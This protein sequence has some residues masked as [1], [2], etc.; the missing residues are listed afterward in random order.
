MGA[1]VASGTDAEG[2]AVARIEPCEALAPVDLEVPGDFS[3][4]AFLLAFAAL[5]PDAAI[6]IEDVGV[7]PTRTGLL[8]VLQRMG[9]TV[10]VRR[11]R[12]A[13][14]EPVAD[15]AAHASALR[16]TRLDAAEV[17]ALI[18]EIPIIAALA[19]RAEGE[20]VV[21]G[22]AELRVKETDRIHAVV[23]NL[24]AVGVPAE[25]TADGFVVV[26]TDA[27][28]QGTVQSFGDHRIAMAFGVLGALPGN[29]I[30]ILGADAVDVSYPGFWTDLRRL[31]RTFPAR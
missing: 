15:L 30:R 11:A 16:G 24:R 10:A 23:T 1:A 18:D 21:S 28:L 13:A 3:S 27:P 2:G 31:E 22:A 25:E 9:C 26:G 5:R 12:L 7:N 17:P 20:T 8:D 29:D 14:L 4:A 6:L 19:A